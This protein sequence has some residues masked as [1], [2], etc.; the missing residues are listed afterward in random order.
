MEDRNIEVVIHLPE[1]IHHTSTIGDRPSL[2]SQNRLKR[3]P[4]CQRSKTVILNL[5]NCSEEG[6][7][8]E[9]S[10]IKAPF[11]SDREIL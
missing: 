4:V 2:T 5:L 1:N 10:K 7:N 8:S 3:L 9:T 11:A 6:I